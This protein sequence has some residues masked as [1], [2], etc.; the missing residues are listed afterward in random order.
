MLHK[1]RSSILFLVVPILLTLLV[2]LALSCSEQPAAVDQGD[3]G[4]GNTGKCEIEMGTGGRFLL[5]LVTD[6]TIAPGHL[7][8]WGMNVMYDTTEGVVSFDVQLVNRSRT[9]IIPPIHFVI[10]EIIPPDIAIIGYDGTSV[11][12]FPYYDFSTKLGDDNI[13]KP[14][15][16]TELVRMYFQTVEPRSFAIGFR[17]DLGQP[18]RGA[19]IAG[20]VYFDGNKNGVRDRCDRCEPGIPGITVGLEKSL[21]ENDK[22]ILLTRTNEKGEYI[23][24]RLRVGVYKVFVHPDPETWNVTSANPLLVTIV[25]GPDGQL[26][27]F[28]GANFGLF[29]KHPPLPDNLFGPIMVGPASPYGTELDS[30]FANPPSYT[31]VLYK[32]FLDVMKPPFAFPSCGV[33]DSASAWINEELVFEYRRNDDPGAALSTLTTVPLPDSLVHTGENAIR[34][35]TYGNKEAVLKWR[36]YREPYYGRD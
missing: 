9:N 30:T 26:H 24:R 8:V 34:I 18:A 1:K 6:S 23:F 27:D 29:P 15:E 22:V 20:V 19:I 4:G 36:V 12:G 35:T 32:Y 11:D 5:G 33:V 7:E 16:G 28:H 10:T 13:L 3:G 2:M 25:K 14:E 21:D 31:P 17:I